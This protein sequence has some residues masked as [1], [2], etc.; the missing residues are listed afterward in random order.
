MKFMR[1]KS[2]FIF[3]TFLG[4]VF[5]G[6]CTQPAQNP[7]DTTAPTVVS[8]VPLTSAI[9]VVPNIDITAT[10]SEAL[11]AAT[12]VADNFT[13]F[14]GATQGLG[15][16]TYADMVATFNP[17]AN[18]AHST[19]FTVTLKT[20]ITDESG[21]GLAADYT[22]SFTTGVALDT[23]TPVVN[24]TLPQ[25]LD[26]NVGINGTISAVFSEA[27]DVS[28]LTNTNFAIL[29][30]TSSVPGSITYDVPTKTVIFAPSINL[31]PGST[32][33]VTLTTGVKDVAGNSMFNNKVWTFT[34]A[35][36]GNGPAPVILG[37]S[38]TFVILAKTAI[39]SVPA[40]VITG[41]IGVSPAAE[42][43]LTGFSQ[44]DAIGYATAPQVTGFIYA[45][46]MAPPA[47]SNMTTAVS[48]META[49]T[50]A[51]GRITPDF[52]NLG[53]G[54]IGGLTLVPGLYTWN[55]A[56]TIPSDVTI[57]GTN[58]NDVWIF[59]ISGNLL[60]SS[61]MKVLLGGNAKAKNIFWQVAG[62]ASLGT[63]SVFEGIILSQTAITLGT[64]A[65]LNGRA[66]AQAQ[67]ALDQAV[68]TQPAP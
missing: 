64:G 50:D 68:V 13:V 61:G 40:S 45:A 33:S 57:S 52:T 37:S 5:L 28:S 27:M 6:S 17:D 65:T 9:E 4:L 54:D 36:A 12:A 42:S 19:N 34:T 16:V 51:A 18:L 38:G 32:Y 30:G 22:W 49:Y 21:N 23:T 43:Y 53:S 48:D 1:A 31:N 63:T 20:G 59:Q 26:V 11:N 29:N 41:N 55:T 60:I 25:D 46:D 2:S 10:F 56:V 67:V 66:L 47:P 58:D 14:A 62:E 3:L 15:V 44:T 39:S 24:S 35:S 8:V 7:G